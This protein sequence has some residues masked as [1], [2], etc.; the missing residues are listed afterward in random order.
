MH[1]APV[2]FSSLPDPEDE[3][4]D[5]TLEAQA[6]ESPELRIRCAPCAPSAQERRD[7]EVLHEPFRAWCRSC[8]AGRAKSDQHKARDAAEKELP[9][10]GVDYGYL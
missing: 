3:Q 4:V 2:D 10:L 9:I 5:D 8:V 7:H 1:V 6:A